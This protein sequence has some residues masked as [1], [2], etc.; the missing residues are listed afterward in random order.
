MAKDVILTPE[1]LEKLKAELDHLSTDKRR[2][3]AERIKEARE[4]G[5]ISENSEYDDA[6]NEQAML[7][8]RIAN[9]QEKIRM[10]TVIEPEDLSTDVVAVGSV[11]HVKD[12]KTGKSV[13]YTIVG[14]AEAKPAENRLSNESPV[15]RALLGRKR[16]DEVSVQVPRG[17]ARKLKITKIE[18]GL[19]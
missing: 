17:P 2:E 1:G 18:V 8:A 10:A 13:K 14:S 16:N 4:F 5:D 6:K 15:G 7:E 19:R 11:V 9:V 3:V 12:E